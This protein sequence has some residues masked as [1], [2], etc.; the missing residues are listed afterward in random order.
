[1]LD[2]I[3]GAPEQPTQLINADPSLRDVHQM[4]VLQN[5]AI[6]SGCKPYH[7][8]TERLSHAASQATDGDLW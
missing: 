4:A 1:M 6:A 5:E 8:T 3:L 7:P 2:R